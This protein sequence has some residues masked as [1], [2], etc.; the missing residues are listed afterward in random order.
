MIHVGVKNG[1]QF[2]LIQLLSPANEY[3]FNLKNGTIYHIKDQYDHTGHFLDVGL[4]SQDIII[5]H[6]ATSPFKT[7]HFVQKEI[8]KI[9]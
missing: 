2:I 7:V 1:R 9:P 3:E 8:Q 6:F 5:R 4:Q